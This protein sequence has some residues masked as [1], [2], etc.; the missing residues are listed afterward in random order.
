MTGRSTG[1]PPGR[2][3]KQPA[4]P[5]ERPNLTDAQ[6]RG[7]EA[8]QYADFRTP[9]SHVAAR[10]GVS[11]VAVIKWR[12]NPEYVRGLA[13]SWAQRLLAELDVDRAREEAEAAARR[14]NKRQR[15]ALTATRVLRDW[16]GPVE[17]PFDGVTYMTPAAYIEHL[18]AHDA[19]HVDDLRRAGA[20]GVTKT[21]GVLVTAR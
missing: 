6:W 10:A 8:E 5:G 1:R 7:I 14:L 19:V 3:R 15:A 18:A 21:T 20:G 2:P 12:R 11:H 13:W 17:S 9:A 4:P 16:C